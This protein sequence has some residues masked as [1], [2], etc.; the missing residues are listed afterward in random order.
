MI[1]LPDLPKVICLDNFYTGSKENVWHLMGE[2]YFEIVRR[3]VCPPYW[4]KVDEVYNLVFPV[5]YQNDPI[6][7]TKTSILVHTICYHC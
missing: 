3:D 5:Y 7:N 1:E 6:Q 2:H 4:T